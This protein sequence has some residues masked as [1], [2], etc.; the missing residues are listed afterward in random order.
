M[1]S[2]LYRDIYDLISPKQFKDYVLS[3]RYSRGLIIQK[4]MSEKSPTDKL[5]K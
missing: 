1:V 5:L 4:F 2:E 3:A